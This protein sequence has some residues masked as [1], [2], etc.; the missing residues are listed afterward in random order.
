MQPLTDGGWWQV[1]KRYRESRQGFTH[2][3]GYLI[4]LSMGDPS[5]KDV[6]AA[7][8]LLKKNRYKS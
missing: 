1:V 8:S 3:K 7:I 5:R 2:R 6:Q 4:W